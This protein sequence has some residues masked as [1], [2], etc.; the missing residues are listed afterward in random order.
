LRGQDAASGI[1]YYDI[2]IDGGTAE[3]FEDPDKR[4]VYATP[5]LGPGTHTILVTAYDAAGN[6]IVDQ[7]QFS[8]VAIGPPT[9][10]E[11]TQELR[12]SDIFVVRGETF[13]NATVTI[14]VENE[15]GEVVLEGQTKSDANGKW[16]FV[17]DEKL[18][19]GAHKLYATVT[20]ERGASSNRTEPQ[21]VIVVPSFLQETG[22]RVT[23]FFA[24]LVPLIG[25]LFLLA[26]LLWY[27]W[28]RFRRFAGTLEKETQ[29][30]GGD[31]HKQFAA[32][33]TSMKEHVAALE[34]AATRREL[35]RE[36]ERMK[37]ELNQQLEDAEKA[38]L[39]EVEG[40]EKDIEREE[41]WFRRLIRK[42]LKLVRRR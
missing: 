2:Q 38:I 33:H 29:K 40:L 4:G 16:T 30:L 8:I 19:E 32:L 6:S 12:T 25:T 17:A 37:D 26:F 42:L 20:D 22:R 11:Y 13:Q 31:V 27:G 10:T 35:T 28:H 41:H 39:G 21:P 34:H 7:E 9:I 14:I 18:P 15:D 24:V 1:A 36:E 23:N 5:A 3:R